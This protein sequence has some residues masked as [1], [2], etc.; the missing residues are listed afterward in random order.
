MSSESLSWS[1]YQRW[2]RWNTLAGDTGM[3]TLTDT[4]KLSNMNNDSAILPWLQFNLLQLTVIFVVNISRNRSFPHLSLKQLQSLNVFTFC[5]SVEKKTKCYCKK[6]MFLNLFV[7]LH[8]TRA[9]V[10]LEGRLYGFI[11]GKM[12]LLAD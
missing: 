11:C 12:C 10:T 3:L 4:R 5:I 1:L 6:M 9:P 7:V 2:P 8:T